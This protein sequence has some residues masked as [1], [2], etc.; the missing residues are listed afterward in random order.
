MFIKLY[1]SSLVIIAWHNIVSSRC[2]SVHW[3]GFP[4]RQQ[5]S[6]DV[7]RCVVIA[8]TPLVVPRRTARKLPHSKLLHRQQPLYKLLRRQRLVLQE[9]QTRFHSHRAIKWSVDRPGTTATK[10]VYQSWLCKIWIFLSS[11]VAVYIFVNL[12]FVFWQGW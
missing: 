5:S 10:C 12:R 11:C 8:Q 2:I 6:M 1:P 4:F 7:R 9:P 3:H